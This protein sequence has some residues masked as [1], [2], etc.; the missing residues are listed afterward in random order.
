MYIFQLQDCKFNDDNIFIPDD[1]LDIKIEKVINKNTNDFSGKYL[2]HVNGDTFGLFSD[3]YTYCSTKYI[4]EK[5]KDKYKLQ[6]KFYRK[7]TITCYLYTEKEKLHK[8]DDKTFKLVKALSLVPLSTFEGYCMFGVFISNTYNGWRKLN[9]GNYFL[10]KL[11]DKKHYI[12]LSIVD[13]KGSHLPSLIDKVKELDKQIHT[14]EDINKIDKFELDY[15]IKRIL[16]KKNYTQYKSLLDSII[17]YDPLQMI[18]AASSTTESYDIKDRIAKITSE[19]LR[20]KS[21]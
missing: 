14:I 12:K 13:I 2:I 1:M 19:L 11:G 5:I 4:L 9:M 21:S 18:I 3:L 7:G 6:Y 17:N 15:E 8:L 16:A 10:M 20:R